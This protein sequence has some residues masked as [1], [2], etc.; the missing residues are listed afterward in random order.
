[1]VEVLIMADTVL[2]YLIWFVFT[3]LTTIITGIVIP[4]ISKWISSK[5]Q[6]EKLQAIITDITTTV[7][8]SVNYLE[9]TVVA[10]YKA[11]GKWNVTAQKKVLKDATD[12]VI[13]NLLDTTKKTIT[14]NNINIQELI[15]RHIESYIQSKK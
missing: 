12:K 15:T 8:T 2:N 11:T 9:Q 14:D 6:N 1:M 13:K 5:T 4:T 7:Q 10:Q 3:I